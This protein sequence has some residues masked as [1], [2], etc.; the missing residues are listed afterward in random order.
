MEHRLLEYFVAVSEELHFTKAADKLNISQPT[1]SQQIRLLEQELGTPLFHRSGKKNFLTQAGQILLEHTRRVFHEL[2]QAKL[3]INELAGVKRGKL[4]IGCSGNHLLL[5]TLITFHRQFPGVELTITELATA[6]T[7]EGLLNNKLDLGIVFLP[8]R[9]EQLVSTPLYDEELVLVVSS[10]HPFSGLQQ[11]QLA[12]LSEIPL[13]L[14]P[15]KFLVRQMLDTACTGIGTTLHP[16]MELS[17]ME[18]Q[19]QM[20]AHNIGGTVLPASYAATLRDTRI[21][22]IPLAE[23]TPRQSVGFVHRKDMYID[24][25]IGAFIDHLTRKDNFGSA[26]SISSL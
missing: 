5:N 20:A 26:S 7:C 12:Q 6:E 4:T 10:L 19:W 2:D 22:M 17:T 9:H 24:S 1:L 25:V 13:I 23:P 11:I 21:T 3:E 8:L 16:I 15:H 18:S 14:F